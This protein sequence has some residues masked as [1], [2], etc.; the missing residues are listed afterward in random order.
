[1]A[2]KWS[3]LALKQIKLRKSFFFLHFFFPPQMSLNRVSSSYLLFLKEIVPKMQVWN[4]CPSPAKP[5]PTSTGTKLDVP[6]KRK[7]GNVN[8]LLKTVQS[9]QTVDSY[10]NLARKSEG[11]ASPFCRDLEKVKSLWKTNKTFLAYHLEVSAVSDFGRMHSAFNFTQCLFSAFM[12]SRPRSL[13]TN[14]PKINTCY[15]VS[16]KYVLFEN[17]LRHLAT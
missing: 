1:M 4:K 9:G 16:P 14:G 11:E 13:F 2:I 6:D 7:L 15:S 12:Y 17:T 8:H 3:K 5:D 10:S